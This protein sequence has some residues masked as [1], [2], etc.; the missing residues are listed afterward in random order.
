MADA[1]L[2]LAV[3]GAQKAS[4][5][6]LA[7]YLQQHPEI[8]FP[9]IKET[10][11]F[12]R[13]LTPDGPM[14]RDISLLNDRFTDAPADSL[15]ADGTPIYLYWPHAISLLKAHNPDMKLVVSLRHP[16]IRA[17]SAWSME[18]RRQREP[19]N[20][21]AAIREGRSR[22]ADAPFG[23]HN[24]YSYVE[25]GFYAKQ[26]ERVFE[27]FEP[28]QVFVIRSDQVSAQDQ[29]MKDL[30]GFLEVGAIEF[31]QIDENVNPSSLVPT[32]GLQDDF[33][34]L[35]DLYSEDLGSLCDMIDVDISDWLSVPKVQ[36]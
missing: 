29:R 17:F 25:R 15:L 7:L 5:T 6:A 24:I 21:S 11:F 3:I 26:I 18:R 27:V 4:T 2:S 35:Q 22:V 9:P 23:V 30:L 34:Y 31:A 33:A 1:Q 13:P 28:E 10:H 32:E 12:R 8:Y 16:A 36:F 14:E 19:L 20:F